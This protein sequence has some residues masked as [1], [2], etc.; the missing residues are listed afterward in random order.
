MENKTY[1]SAAKFVDQMINQHGP[2]YLSVHKAI[3]NNC[4]NADYSR[5]S[6]QF[7]T[8]VWQVLNA[9]YPS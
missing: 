9:K 8:Y 6:N 5:S 1:K 2:N 4:V 3:L 7:I